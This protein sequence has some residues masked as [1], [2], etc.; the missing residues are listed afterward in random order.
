MPKAFK[1]IKLF[2]IFNNL[3]YDISMKFEVINLKEI[4]LSRDDVRAQLEIVIESAKASGVTAIKLMHGYGSSFRGGVILNELNKLLPT[5]LRSKQITHYFFGSAWTINNADCQK[6]I[7][8]HPDC[9]GD[10]D[11]GKSNPGIT[12]IGV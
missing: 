10:E 2:Y 7:I 6:F 3:C 4:V 11:L 1:T 12:V 8:S 5:M 9:L